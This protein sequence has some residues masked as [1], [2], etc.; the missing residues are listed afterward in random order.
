MDQNT[1][2]KFESLETSL[3]SRLNQITQKLENKH[4]STSK[5][6]NKS[7]IKD[8]TIIINQI[9]KEIA[10]MKDLA[11]QTTE[12]SQNQDLISQLKNIISS[13]KCNPSVPSYAQVVRNSDSLNHQIQQQQRITEEKTI[14]ISANPDQSPAN[15]LLHVNNAIKNARSNDRSFK[16]NK[17]IKSKNGA[18]VKLPPEENIDLLIEDLKDYDQLN[19]VAAIY[20]PTPLDPTIVLKSIAKITNINELPEIL[21]KM[22]PQ[23]QGCEKR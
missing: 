13:N 11:I 14:V 21:C 1:I 19:N 23:L 3:A 6:I 2:Q 16:I 7:D 20:K 22:N 12:H 8:I 5:Q 17:I 4:Q 15:I 10:L 9:T 18:V